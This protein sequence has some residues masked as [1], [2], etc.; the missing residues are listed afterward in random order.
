MI[1]IT[2]NFNRLKKDEMLWLYSH[3]CKHGHRY[4][5]HPKCF[6]EEHAELVDAE[7]VGFVDI[8][9]SGLNADFGWIFC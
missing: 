1:P 3:Y 5:E 8:E 7:R 9:T 6:H 2:T 4:T